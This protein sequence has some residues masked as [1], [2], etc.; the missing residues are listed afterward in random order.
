LPAMPSPHGRGLLTFLFLAAAIAFSR[1]DNT[2]TAVPA[3]RRQPYVCGTVHIA[4]PFY[5]SNETEAPHCG[6]PGLA[7]RCDGGTTAILQLGADNYTVSRIDY[8]NLTVSLADAAAATG[9]C[10]TVDHNVTFPP[11]TQLFLSPAAVDYLLFFLDCAFGPK[12]PAA[13]D[14][15]KPPSIKPITCGG[16]SD[17]GPGPGAVASFLLPVGAVPPGDW[18]RACR[19]VFQAPVLK[20]VIPRDA[21]DSAWRGG[22][23]GAALRAGFQVGWERS[24]GECGRCEQGNG[25]CE[26]GSSGGF[27]GCVCADGRVS[28]AGCSKIVV[29]DSDSTRIALTPCPFF[30][31]E[32]LV[33]RLIAYHHRN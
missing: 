15:P 11:G 16:G 20:N 28:G 27:L 1:G 26:Y 8:D 25:K 2:Y 18:P 22:G 12:L 3:C 6:Y 30:E 32:V 13:A 23:Y 21:Q 7:V 24:S 14:G 5:L 9:S 29:S 31:T 17:K 4:Y 19:A 33:S 10:V